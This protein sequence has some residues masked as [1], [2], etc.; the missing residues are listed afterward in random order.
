MTQ[1][2]PLRFVTQSDAEVEEQPW[3]PHEWLCRPGL[4]ETEDLLLVRV[5]IPPGEAH[6][7]HHHPA[8]EEIMYV[9]SGEAEQWVQ[10]E[11]R[12]LGPG[13]I[14]H[15]PRGVVHGVYNEGAEPL[16]FL[17]VLSPATAEGPDTVD[18]SHEA[19]WRTL[20]TPIDYSD[21]S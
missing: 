15:I 9:L 19:P 21:A 17:A 10:E 12:R 2:T 5:H 13:E 3:G 20:K 18:V 16:V 8:M 1:N 7:F 4:T 14:A 6:Q 11:K